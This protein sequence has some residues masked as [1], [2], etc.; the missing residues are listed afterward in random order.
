MTV[1]LYC[2]L[3]IQTSSLATLTR[4]NFLYVF[5]YL[6]SFPLRL[7]LSKDLLRK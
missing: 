2:D 1:D 3:F 7:E 5:W 4:M 6:P